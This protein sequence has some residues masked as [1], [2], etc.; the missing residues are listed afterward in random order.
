H[1]THALMTTTDTATASAP[2]PQTSADEM[3]LVRV[4]NLGKI[5]CRDLRRALLY[6]VT[7]SLRDLM[8]GYKGRKAG[9][10]G[11]IPL[12]KHEFWANQGVSFELRRGECLG[13]IGH[14]GA[15]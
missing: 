14:N 13:L 6:G 12:R 9:P 3:P 7:D 11:E 2:A 5:F 4:Q 1:R 10:D 15:G 8:P